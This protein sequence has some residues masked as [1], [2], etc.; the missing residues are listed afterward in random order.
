MA[1]KLKTK[2]VH[3]VKWDSCVKDVKAKESSVNPY[4][5]CTSSL[6]EKSFTK[7]YV[8]KNI[9]TGKLVFSSGSKEQAERF[10][11]SHRF[12]GDSSLRMRV[13]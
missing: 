9:Y 2:K 8:I 7:K 10:L 3:S 4:A 13:E 1:Y 12:R 11:T 5:V 6:K